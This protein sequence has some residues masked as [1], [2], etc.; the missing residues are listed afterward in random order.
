MLITESGLYSKT[1]HALLQYAGTKKGQRSSC[2]PST[3]NSIAFS[4][5]TLATKGQRSPLSDGGPTGGDFTPSA[6]IRTMPCIVSRMINSHGTEILHVFA[7]K[8]IPSRPRRPR[9]TRMLMVKVAFSIASCLPPPSSKIIRDRRQ[10]EP[11]PPLPQLQLAARAVFSTSMT[12][13]HV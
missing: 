13:H 8:S 5:A 7:L 2:T 9:S 12:H 4:N 11:S 6:S 1:I 3:H 10:L